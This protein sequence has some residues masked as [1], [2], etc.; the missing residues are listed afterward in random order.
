M[1]SNIYVELKQTAVTID[2]EKIYS[3]VLDLELR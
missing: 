2:L 3:L 1:L